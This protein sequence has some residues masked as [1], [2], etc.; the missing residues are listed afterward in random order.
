MTSSGKR[1]YRSENL[2]NTNNASAWP[3]ELYR[4]FLGR[5]VPLRDEKGNIIKGYGT[6]HD[7]EDRKRAEESVRS[8]EAYLAEAQRLSHTGSWAW[9]PDHDIRVLV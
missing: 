1:P 3:M 9:S 8:S 5:N 6:L 2:W 7:I 4:W